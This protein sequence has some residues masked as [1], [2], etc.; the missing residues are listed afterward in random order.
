MNATAYFNP[1]A[2]KSSF[3]VK[4]LSN[5]PY[6]KKQETVAATMTL[7]GRKFFK[8]IGKEP[9]KIPELATFYGKLKE[10][11]EEK[12]AKESKQGRHN[13]KKKNQL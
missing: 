8:P 5:S 13:F 12:P 9:Q 3:R 1:N 10:K 7:Y 6:K 11:T 4:H 2:E